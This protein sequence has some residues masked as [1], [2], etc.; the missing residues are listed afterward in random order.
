MGVFVAIMQVV[1]SAVDY[2]NGSFYYNYAG[3]FF[4]IAM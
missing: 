1:I 4:L 2:A 3:E